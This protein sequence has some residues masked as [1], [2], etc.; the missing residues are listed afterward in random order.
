ML[1]TSPVHKH[2]ALEQRS[3][4]F[5]KSPPFARC[6][7]ETIDNTMENVKEHVMLR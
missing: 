5:L 3:P 2:G 6:L 7:Y 1:Q 4:N